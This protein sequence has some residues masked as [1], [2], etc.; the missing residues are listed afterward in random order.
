[1]VD[2]GSYTLFAQ[3]CAG[4]RWDG[5]LQDVRPI[6]NPPMHYALDSPLGAESDGGDGA[7]PT[8]QGVGCTV[9]GSATL[10]LK[11]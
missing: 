6:P 5:Y 8:W 11:G 4:S 9:M 1:M 10:T 7:V 3:D 2:P